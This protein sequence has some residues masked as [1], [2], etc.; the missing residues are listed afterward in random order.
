MLV[1][2]AEDG[3]NV[4][5]D[6][7]QNAIIDYILSV[8]TIWILDSWSFFQFSNIDRWDILDIN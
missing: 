1:T 5:H 7:S 2:S 3:R 4:D 6:H 8:I